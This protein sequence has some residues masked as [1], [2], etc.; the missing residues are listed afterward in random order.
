MIK[1][2]E[3]NTRVASCLLRHRAMIILAYCNGVVFFLAQLTFKNKAYTIVNS[4][5]R[6]KIAVVLL[7]M[8]SASNIRNGNVL[9]TLT[10]IV[11][12]ELM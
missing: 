3:N 6:T 11:F 4:G 8:Y 5:R 7:L 12:A 9:R 2:F 10:R 1:R